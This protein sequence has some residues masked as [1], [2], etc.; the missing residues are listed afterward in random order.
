M[1]QNPAGDGSPDRP[2]ASLSDPFPALVA[3]AADAFGVSPEALLSRRKTKDLAQPRHALSF[4]AHRTLG[5]SSNRI[6]RLIGRDHTTVLY[7]LERHQAMMKASAAYRAQ[8]AVFEAAARRIAFDRAA[9]RA[10]IPC[11]SAD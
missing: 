5:L 7:S 2:S 1:T 8:V 9:R 4:F 3:A 11:S 6:G 10:A